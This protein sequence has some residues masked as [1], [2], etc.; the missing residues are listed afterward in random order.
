ML[1]FADTGP[2]E[3]DDF[4]P[5]RLDPDNSALTAVVSASEPDRVAWTIH[6]EWIND[7]ESEPT[8]S[9]IWAE[10]PD[11][12][13]GESGWKDIVGRES[14]ISYPSPSENATNF[15]SFGTHESLNHNHVRITGR[16]GRNF[17]LHWR[18]TLEVN[19]APGE[20]LEIVETIAFK[21]IAIIFPNETAVDLEVAQRAA[22]RHMARSEFGD[23]EVSREWVTFQVRTN[24]A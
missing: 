16:D 24:L 7:E 22:I 1:R 15:C 14:R 17:S 9:M 10:I 12:S 18:C 13:F 8:F 6:I 11:L 2:G 4:H 3:R 20:V 21:R 23:P 19:P 5:Y